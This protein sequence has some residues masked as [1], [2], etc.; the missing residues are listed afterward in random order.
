MPYKI[1]RRAVLSGSHL[2]SLP[3]SYDPK[4]KNIVCHWQNHRMLMAVASYAIGEIIV[5]HGREHLMTNL[6]HG[7][8]GAHAGVAHA[9]GCNPDTPP[10]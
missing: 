3:K 5:C 7:D 6:C 8:V 1:V 10:S 2:M 4:C 9:A